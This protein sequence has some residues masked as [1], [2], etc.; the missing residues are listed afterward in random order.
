LVQLDGSEH[1]W[2]EGRGSKC[3]LLVFI[4]DAT[5][6]ILY[7]V[8]VT[9]EDTLNLMAATK[10]YLL[11]NG[12][13]LFWYVDK[14]SIYKI[15]R[16]ADIEEDLRDEQPLTQFTRAMGEFGIQV[17]NAHSPQAKGRVERGFGTHQD[18]LVKELRLAR[19]STMKAANIFLAEVYV[20]KHN[21]R[22]AVAPENGTNV[23]RPLLKRHRLD[24]TLSVRTKRTVANDFTVRQDN[25]FFQLLADQPVRVR[26][27]DKLL[28]EMRLDGSRH[29]RFKDRYLNFKSIAKPPY[30]PFYA[31][32]KEVVSAAGLP[33]F[34][35][36]AK[37]H[38]WRKSYM[39]IRRAPSVPATCL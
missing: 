31:G 16:Q 15:N 39:G 24:E 14:D 22:F 12:R 37:N 19:I 38:P 10:S 1:D 29:L 18:R 36:P 27:K 28:V 34:N 23:H 30:R 17:I 35:K 3:A 9:V 2:F 32:K 26:P 6:R 21:A 11:I 33:R 8:F 25:R 7:A 5:S 4:D 20:P 13:P